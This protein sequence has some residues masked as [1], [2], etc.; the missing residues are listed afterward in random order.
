MMA[1]VPL[2]GGLGGLRLQLCVEAWRVYRQALTP[3]SI[4]THRKSYDKSVHSSLL[5]RRP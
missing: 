1:W 5:R 4:A 3:R 2:F